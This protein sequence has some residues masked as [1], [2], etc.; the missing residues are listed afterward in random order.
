MLQM[1]TDAIGNK[2][3]ELHKNAAYLMAKMR[4]IKIARG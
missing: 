4:A 1:G 3:L 2:Q